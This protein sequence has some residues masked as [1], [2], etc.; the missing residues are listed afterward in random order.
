MVLVTPQTLPFVPAAG[1]G[2]PHLQTLFP[3][4]FRHPKP[5]EVTVETFELS[6][7]DFVDCYWHENRRET[8][9]DAPVVT[10]FHG[11]EGSF[12]SSY[13]R[14]MM[15]A[16][17]REGFVPVV[18]H[19]RGCS[20]RPN[21]LPRSYHSGDTADARA[22]LHALRQRY[23]KAPLLAAGY[24]LGG[25]MLLKLLGEEGAASPLQA[26]VAVSAPMQLAL[27]ADRIDRGFSKCYQA[28]LLRDLRRTLREKY[29]RFD[30]ESLIGLPE[31]KVETLKTFR[32]FD[33]AYTAPIHG[34]A[35]ADDYYR[36]CSAQQYLQDIA[37]PTLILH[38]LDDPF[39]PPEVLP[40][41][42]T[43]PHNVTLETSTHGGHV[44]FV[45]GTPLRPSYWLEERI[46][47]FFRQ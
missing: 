21:R 13:I 3:P 25:N 2:N 30:M 11:L 23:P 36:R 29:R 45:G 32:A 39:M 46:I 4:L 19:F 1:L 18:M 47:R 34:F 40:D 8:A 14:G 17:A 15:H 22:W 41:P 31:A 44:G 42:K 24:S 7:G 10:L 27:S 16:L 38:A 43:L 5:P 6:D 12:R 26:A 33:D 9:E 28:Y 37:V 35:S 20:G